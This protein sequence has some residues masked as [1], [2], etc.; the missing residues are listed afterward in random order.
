ML[1]LL[2][3]QSLFAK[4][5]SDGISKLKFWDPIY[6]DSLT[7]IAQLPELAALIYRTT[8]KSGEL[9]P[10]D[11]QLDW[12]GNLAH[13]MGAPFECGLLEHQCSMLATYSGVCHQL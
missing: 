3:P 4:A 5:Y 8:Y 7:L 13:M 9:I 12:A 6:E 10:A 1:A 11:P 2:Q